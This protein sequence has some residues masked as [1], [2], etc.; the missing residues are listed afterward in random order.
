MNKLAR[1]K[2]IQVLNALCEGVSMRAASRLADVSY[3]TVFALLALISGHRSAP[4]TRA[5]FTRSYHARFTARFMMPA[6]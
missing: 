2:R 4:S 3:N 6:T 5:R 1:E